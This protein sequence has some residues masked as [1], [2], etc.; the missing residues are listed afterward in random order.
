MAKTRRSKGR[1]RTA[2]AGNA[3]T[4]QLATAGPSKLTEKLL[5]TVESVESILKLAS[6]LIRIG[7]LVLDALEQ[8]KEVIIQGP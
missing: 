3:K 1:R 7:R 8:I 2:S 5:A 6:T 4:P